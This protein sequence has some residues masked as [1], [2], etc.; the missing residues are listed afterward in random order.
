MTSTSLDTNAL[1]DHLFR[2]E[3]GKMVAALTRLF[4]PRYLELAEDVV[5][6]TL[7]KALKD[8][9]FGGDPTNR[10]PGCTVWPVTWPSTTCGGM[11]EGWNC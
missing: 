5:Q 9:P 6:E 4:G 8:W 1:A 2:R 7:L 11:H 10:P 3:A